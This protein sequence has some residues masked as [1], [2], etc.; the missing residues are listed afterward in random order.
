MGYVFPL[1]TL[2]GWP[3]LP[4]KNQSEVSNIASILEIC[5][6]DADRPTD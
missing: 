2:Q 5:R 1:F 6:L 4:A 3:E